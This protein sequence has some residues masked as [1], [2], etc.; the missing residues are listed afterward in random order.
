MFTF[1]DKT[2]TKDK[3]S[4]NTLQ[5]VFTNKADCKGLDT[6]TGSGNRMQDQYKK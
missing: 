2:K 4:S 1:L 3:R 5:L 6:I